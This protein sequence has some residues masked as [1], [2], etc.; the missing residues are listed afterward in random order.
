MDRGGGRP[1]A[2]PTQPA[3]AAAAPGEDG[4]VALGEVEDADVGDGFERRSMRQEEAIEMSR[5]EEII[6][7]LEASLGAEIVRRRRAERLA[8]AG[9]QVALAKD[10]WR[11]GWSNRRI[12]EELGVTLPEARRMTIR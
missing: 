6:T 8:E 7:R 1:Q 12:A 11:Q 4:A 2:A 9:G 10:L 3:P 5:Y